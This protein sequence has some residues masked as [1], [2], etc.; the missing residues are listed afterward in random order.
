MSHLFIYFGYWY[1]SDTVI[2]ILWCSTDMDV[3]RLQLLQSYDHIWRHSTSPNTLRKP[4]TSDQLKTTLVPIMPCRDKLEGDAE[5]VYKLPDM[6]MKCEPQTQMKPQAPCQTEFIILLLFGI[7][8]S[9]WHQARW[10][11]VL[12]GYI[13]ILIYTGLKLGLTHKS[14]IYSS[15]QYQNIAKVCFGRMKVELYIIYWFLLFIWRII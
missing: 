1:L 13:W 9:T 12:Q 15:L 11:S 8:P 2:F 4:V 7:K 5:L 3:I 10:A 6:F 14:Y